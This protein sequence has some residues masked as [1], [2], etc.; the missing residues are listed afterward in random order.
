MLVDLLIPDFNPAR[1]VEYM[2]RTIASSLAEAALQNIYINR[3]EAASRGIFDAGDFLRWQG[4]A[5]RAWRASRQ[6]R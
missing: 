6:S 5:Q 3:R 1:D 2:L 4:R